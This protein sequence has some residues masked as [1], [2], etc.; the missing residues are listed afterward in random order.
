MHRWE[1]RPWQRFHL[2]STHQPDAQNHEI[3]KITCQNIL[4]FGIMHSLNNKI[5]TMS[6]ATRTQAIWLHLAM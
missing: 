4:H 2:S 6:H 5:Q 3:S 1:Q